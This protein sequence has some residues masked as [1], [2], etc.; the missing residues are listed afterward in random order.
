MKPSNL[1]LLALLTTLSACGGGSGGNGN[2]TVNPPAIPAPGGATADDL[3]SSTLQSAL[4]AEMPLSSS[5]GNAF[6]KLE[7][8]KLTITNKMD[9]NFEIKIS[10]FAPNGKAVVD[11]GINSHLTPAEA[12]GIGF[13]GANM[14]KNPLTVQL[15]GKSAGLE[16][17]EFGYWD[18]G[19]MHI[20]EGNTFKGTLRDGIGVVFMGGVASS[21][22]PPINSA[23]S[24]TGRAYGWLFEEHGNKTLLSGTASLTFNNNQHNLSANFNN[25]ANVLTCND[26]ANASSFTLTGHGTFNKAYYTPQFYGASTATEVV[27]IL[28]GTQGES[29]Y[30]DMSFGAR[31]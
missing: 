18:A 1:S 26:C 28:R 15:G 3:F 14:T 29:K 6:V 5:D 16:Y 19:E 22:Q 21:I 9:Y 20:Y 31:K 23:T 12:A 17:A 10:D 2:P 30:F 4:A 8:G 7:N 25:G 27:G 24:F 11:A 13:P